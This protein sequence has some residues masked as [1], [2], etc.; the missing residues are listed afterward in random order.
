MKTSNKL[1]YMKGTLL[2][3]LFTLMSPDTC[4]N[5]E[6]WDSNREDWS[7]LML[8]I[9]NEQIEDVKNLIGQ[10]VDVNFVTSGVNSRW[11]LT[12]LEVAIR[13]EYD[14]VIE[15]LLLTTRISE[16]ETYLMIACGQRSA[17]TVELLI[18]Y[19]ANPNDTLENGHS[20][21]VMAASFGSFEILGCLLRNG[22]NC[23]QTRKVDGI[24]ILM[25][26]VLK[27]DVKKSNSC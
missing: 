20:V 9:Y 3:I 16:P 10:N 1:K 2:L 26:A 22:S 21:S 25:F 27:A 12:A 19:G 23:K 8:A 7:P 4:A 17:K 14:S 5:K 15:I 6:K 13:K 24:T 11:H 18:K